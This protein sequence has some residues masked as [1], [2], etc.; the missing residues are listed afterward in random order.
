VLVYRRSLGQMLVAAG[1]S[2]AG[3]AE[4]ERVLAAYEKTLGPDHPRTG[5]AL[6]DLADARF[7]SG[8]RD[9]VE[10]QMRRGLDVLRRQLAPDSTLLA[11]GQSRLGALLCSE[12][13]AAEGL[14]LLRDGIG[15]LRASRPAGDRDLLAAD[16]ALR[17]TCPG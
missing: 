10:T 4:L 9:G 12:G 11:A 15:V 2:R 16:A 13:R 5:N 3:I 8:E 7:T 6:L 17:T 14:P 1:D